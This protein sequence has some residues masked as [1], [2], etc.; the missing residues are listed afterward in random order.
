MAAGVPAT[1]SALQAKKKKK[2]TENSLLHWIS[3][4]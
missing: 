4:V 3:S 1:I 2:L